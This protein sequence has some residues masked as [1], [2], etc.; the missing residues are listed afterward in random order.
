MNKWN[1]TQP[2]LQEGDL[3]LMEGNGLPRW[4]WPL[5]RIEEILVDEQGIAQRVRL[6]APQVADP[7]SSRTLI[8]SVHSI[9]PLECTRENLP[10]PSVEEE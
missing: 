1:A 8:R 3:V 9:Y 7:T 5:A 10:S 4:Q 6:R 2:N